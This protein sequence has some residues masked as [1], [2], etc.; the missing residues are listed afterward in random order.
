MNA[1]RHCL[2]LLAGA[3]LARGGTEEFF[4]RVA[5]ALTVSSADARIRARVSG[6][7][8]LEG[9]AV[10]L[11]APGVLRTTRG[12]WL[13]PRLTTFLDAQIGPGVY[14]FAQAR[15]DHGFD[16]GD[17]TSRGRLDEIAVRYSPWRDGRLH[18]QAGRFATLVGNWANR[19]DGWSNPFITAP[20]PYEHLTGMWDSDAIRNSTVLL[21]WSHVRP[22]LPAGVKAIEKALRVPIV[23]GPAYATGA[24]VAGEAGPWRYA[25]EL[26]SSALSSRPEAWAHPREQRHHPTWSA[27]LGYRPGPAWSFGVSASAGP[28]LRES[29]A[30][31]VP[32]GR[33]RGDYRQT[34]LAHDAGFA[35]R[36]LQVWAE[37]YASRFAIPGV[38]DADTLAWYVE[39]KY[40]LTPRFF[41]AVRWNQQIFGTIPER[42][43][44]V[45]WGRDVARL[46]V[47]AGYRCSPQAQLKLQY[48]LQ[49]GDSG[50]RR[51]TR[52]LGAQL[53]VR[54]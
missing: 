2:C 14:V 29:A 40:K 49:R 44:A 33:N 16:P 53:T 34:V 15:A 5:Q 28:Y 47:S 30:R 48:S 52:L 32:A 10:Q 38:A 19:H 11:P 50:P 26:K 46:D 37:I 13:T 23:W 20:L 41:G 6:T 42:G 1:L 43:A 8:E 17:D 39:T 9:Y 35:W 21:Q 7:M 27:R 31:S 45:E 51:H 18:V 3:A 4:D 36:H 25:A 22:G 24:A 54:F 12:R